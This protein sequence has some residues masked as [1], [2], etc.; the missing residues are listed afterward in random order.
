MG[1]Y[2]ESIYNLNIEYLENYLLKNSYKK[3][4][5]IQIM[6][7]LYEKRVNSFELMT[8]LGKDLIQK[9]SSDFYFDSLKICIFNFSPF[10]R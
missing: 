8:N 7:W 9:L 2:M 10:T 6:E 1:V 5:A 4:R 3:Y